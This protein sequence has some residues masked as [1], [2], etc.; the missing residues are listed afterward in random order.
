MKTTALLVGL[1]MVGMGA[2]APG[3]IANEST[4]LSLS[5]TDLDMPALENEVP[6]APVADA[7]QVSEVLPVGEFS[8]VSPTHWAYGAV[9]DLAA[10]YGCLT[11]YPDGTFRGDQSVTRYEFAAAL[12]SC[13]GAVM[14]QLDAQQQTEV[15]AIFEDLT[16]LQNELGDLSGDVEAVESEVKLK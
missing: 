14:Q 11:G 16:D 5:M 13:L 2:I 10:N 3:A 8:D 9:N 12:D 1:T 15:D 6:S 4:S 7:P